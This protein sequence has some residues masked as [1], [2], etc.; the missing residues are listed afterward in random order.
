MVLQA[1]PLAGAIA[2]S[3]GALETPPRILAVGLASASA[4]ALVLLKRVRRAVL[5][6]P[7]LL[8]TVS[9]ATVWGTP[10]PAFWRLIDGLHEAAGVGSPFAPAEQPALHDLVIVAVCALAVA[11]VIATM[12]GRP[13]LAGVAAALGVGYPATLL[14]QHGL[15]FGALAAACMVWPTM[16]SR[17]R[18]KRTFLVGLA[19]TVVVVAGSATLADAGLQPEGARVDWRGWSPIGGDRAGVGVSY[20]WDANYLGIRFPDKPTV[21]LRVR[22]PRRL[23]YWRASTLDLFTDDHWVENL[24]PVLIAGG[25]RALPSDLLLPE[26]NGAALVRQEVEV[27]ALDD[28]RLIAV[29][30]PVRVQ[31]EDVSRVIYLSGGVMVAARGLER[32]SRYTVWSNAPRPTPAALARSKPHTRV[33]AQRYLELGRSRLPAFGDPGRV[34]VVD[35]VFRDESL[36]PAVALSTALEAGTAPDGRQSLAVRSDDRA[37]ELAS[38]DRQLRVHRDSSGAARGGAAARRLRDA[39]EAGVLPALRRDDG[40][41][42]PAARDSGPGRGRVHQR[43][44]DGR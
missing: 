30:Q 13:L 41:H 2:V 37:R 5:A 4:L 15:A 10:R 34:R 38:C 24:Y 29:S 26:G 31:S 21:V 33:A 22:A 42:A 17:S 20:V 1:A 6:A 43:P 12:A 14:E 39:V 35:S 9:C 25:D 18:T 11:V 19:T 27:A 23:L 32:G 28:D 44:L 16:V 8:V 36:P 7:V 3:W 40:G